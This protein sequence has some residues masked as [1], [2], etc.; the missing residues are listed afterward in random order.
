MRVHGCYH[1]FIARC[2][3]LIIK[4]QIK[5]SSFV[6]SWL[7]LRRGG[8]QSRKFHDS[9]SCGLGGYCDHKMIKITLLR[10]WFLQADRVLDL[11]A[12]L[13]TIEEPPFSV[14]S[15]RFSH[16]PKP[17]GGTGV[18]CSYPSGSPL[19]GQL[20]ELVSPTAAPCPHPPPH[21]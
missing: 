7:L 10:S 9:F 1:V 11:S 3:F 8:E 4:Q 19:H 16:S 15:S 6:K 21:S 2:C 17:A 18:C 13:E 14:P 5:C 12:R 20:G